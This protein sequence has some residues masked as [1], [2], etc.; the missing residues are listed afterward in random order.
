M[1]TGL[2]EA[3]LATRLLVER[4]DVHEYTLRVLNWI[5]HSPSAV[6]NSVGNIEA[7]T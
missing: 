1:G 4:Q 2:P 5:E 6:P 3:L 7:E